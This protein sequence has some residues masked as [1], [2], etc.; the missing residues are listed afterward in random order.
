VS[1]SAVESQ[2]PEA[3]REKVKVAAIV[4]A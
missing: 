1:C 4:G 3:Q 2:V